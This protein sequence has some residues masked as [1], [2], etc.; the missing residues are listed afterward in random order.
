M[1]TILSIIGIVLIIIGGVY[2]Y[3]AWRPQQPVPA[4]QVATS[5]QPE[6]VAPDPGVLTQTYTSE[7]EGFSVRYPTDYTVA[8]NY[9]Y[10][11][12]S[13]SSAI[14]GVQFRIP[15]SAAT[16]TNLSDDT[17]LSIEMLP[18]SATSTC[19]ADRFLEPIRASTTE[20]LQNGVTYSIASS[21]GAAAGNRYEETVYA[22]PSITACIGVRYFIHY[23]VFENYE[24]GTV[25]P[26][27][28]VAL[29]SQFDAIRSTLVLE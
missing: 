24:P 17:Y 4:L 11:A 8:T 1:K 7:G 5:T 14:K 2:A 20:L 19:T 21:T 16:G 6:L 25:R 9:T 18:L 29:I 26:F 28:R 27:D 22:R 23:G 10:T 12:L 3:R 13:P 15:A